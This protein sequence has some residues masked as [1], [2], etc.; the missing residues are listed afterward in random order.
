MP[1]QAFNHLVYLDHNMGFVLSSTWWA[2]RQRSNTCVGFNSSSDSSMRWLCI[3][4][5]AFLLILMR[6]TSSLE[7]LTSSAIFLINHPRLLARHIPLQ[8]NRLLGFF[9]LCKRVLMVCQS[10]WAFVWVGN[11]GTGSDCSR[12]VSLSLAILWLPNNFVH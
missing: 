5:I 8:P 4:L 9:R 7:S 11:T 3:T 2:I 1:L 12:V 6:S 10:L